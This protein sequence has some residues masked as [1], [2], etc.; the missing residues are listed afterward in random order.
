MEDFKNNPELIVDFVMG[1][2]SVLET[3]NDNDEYD[4]WTPD[5]EYVYKY[6]KDN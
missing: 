3:Y 4:V 1:E 5:A 6:T 2:K